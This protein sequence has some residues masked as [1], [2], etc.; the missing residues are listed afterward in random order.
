MENSTAK[1]ITSKENVLLSKKPPQVPFQAIKQ[2]GQVLKHESFCG[3]HHQLKCTMKTM[4]S[5]VIFPNNKSTT[6][7]KK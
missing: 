3:I 6:I 5:I 2:P 4:L 1:I 7:N